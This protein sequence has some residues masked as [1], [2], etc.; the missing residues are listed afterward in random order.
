M[1]YSLST[2]QLGFFLLLLT[3]TCFAQSTVETT[4]VTTARIYF[5]NSINEAD[6]NY[7]I[8]TFSSLDEKVIECKAVESSLFI[9]ITYT[10]KLKEHTI[11]EVL[12]QNGY[13][14]YLMKNDHIKIVLTRNGE[15]VEEALK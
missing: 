9:S 15:A 2:L 1:K 3:R 8:K 14:A 5:N 10:E 4:T 13:D 6:K 7:I 12:Q 11:L